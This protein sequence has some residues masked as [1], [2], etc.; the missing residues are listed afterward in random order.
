MESK[1]NKSYIC[2]KIYHSLHKPCKCLPYGRFA[3]VIDLFLTNQHS[4]YG[5]VLLFCFQGNG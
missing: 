1:Y 2:K 5:L 4:D 3:P